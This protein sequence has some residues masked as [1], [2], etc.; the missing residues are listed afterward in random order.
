MKRI[1]ITGLLVTAVSASCLM[2]MNAF[3][4]SNPSGFSQLNAQNIMARN[5]LSNSIRTLGSN[6]PLIQAYGLVILQQPDIKVEAMSSLT[7]HQQFARNNVRQWMDEYNP[8]LMN[9]N[10]DM[11]RFSTRFNSYY[12]RLYDLAGKVNES[13]QAKEDFVNAFSR[14]QVQVQMIQDEME[15]T[16][17]EINRFNTLLVK[18]SET[19]SARAEL[20]IQS[21]NGS[22]G[23]IVQLRADIKRIQEE[24]QAELTKI[25]NRPKEIIKGS[26]NIG[27]QVFNITSTGA[28][29]KTV[30]FV[31]IGN[32]S[33][34]LI[35]VSDS[36]ARESAHIIEQKQKE[37]IE[38]IR[39]LSQTQIQATGITFIEDQVNGFTELIN[40]QI[41]T[42]GYLVSDWKA[43]NETMNQ[44]KMDLSAGVNIESDELQKQL[45]QLK[46]LSD[47]LNKQTNQYEDF[48]TNVVVN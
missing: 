14:L 6:S 30:D 15:Q 37:L 16:S 45:I 18:D 21:L 43:I 4:E 33:D 1:F 22:N 19:L 25:L 34:E 17:L 42:L 31:S 29:S 47:E 46:K 8:K 2:P 5:T 12:S 24:I 32:L 28:Q 44:I 41:I 23:D 26:I 3:A 27:K 36:Q 10:Q 13:E 39:K 48:G 35:N 7:T 40:R 9:L 20:A 38:L 11:M